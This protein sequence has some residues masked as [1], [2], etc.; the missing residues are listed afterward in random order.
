MTIMKISIELK[1]F[2]IKG[3]KKYLKSYN[4][5]MNK[6]LDILLKETETLKIQYI[7]KM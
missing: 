5:K 3:I 2:E 4:K 7:E 6:L 1:D